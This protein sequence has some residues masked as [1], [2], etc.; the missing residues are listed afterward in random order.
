MTPLT[1]EQKQLVFDYSFELTSEHQTAEAERLLAT[2]Q[3]A[4]E[5]HLSLKAALSPLDSVEPEPCPDELAEGTIQRLKEQAQAEFGPGRGFRGCLESG[6]GMVSIARELESRSQRESSFSV[7]RHQS[8]MNRLSI[9]C[10]MGPWIQ[11]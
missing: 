9:S 10:T 7:A 6:E 2:N 1:D 3:E 5:L 4:A 8:R 11:T